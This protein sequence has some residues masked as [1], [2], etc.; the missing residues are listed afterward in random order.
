MKLPFTLPF[1]NKPVETD[2]YLILV[3]R[4]EKISAVILEEH[5]EAL[6]VKNLYEE[7]LETPLEQ[8]DPDT[9]TQLLDKTIS[10]AEE[11]FLF[12]V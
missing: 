3:L 7:I 1:G 5:A 4:D 12:D 10:K 2:Y 11:V 6:S 9:L 8:I